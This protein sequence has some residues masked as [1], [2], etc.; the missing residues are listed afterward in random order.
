MNFQSKHKSFHSRKC[1]WK[2][3]LRNCGHFVQGETS[4]WGSDHTCDVSAKPGCDFDSNLKMDM[5][6]TKA[7]Q[8]AYYHLH[9]IRRIRKFLSQE[10]T[11]TIFTCIHYKPD[12]LLQQFDEWT[13]R[14]S[15]QET[16]ACAKHSCQTSF[17]SEEI[18]L[19]NSCTRYASLAS[20]QIPDWI[21]NTVDRLQRTSWQGTYLHPRNDHPIK[22]S[23]PGYA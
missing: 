16:P 3:P 20:S 22:N 7:C 21:Q 23:L 1:I 2:Y 14:E 6:I 13:T 10:A 12:W 4:G 9:N 17:Q 11:C 19:H 8:I 18:W 5:Q 15:H